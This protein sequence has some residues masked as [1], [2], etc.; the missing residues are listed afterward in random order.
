MNTAYVL[1]VVSIGGSEHLAGGLSH[2]IP[3]A[4]GKCM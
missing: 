4:I 3:D 1:D 2:Q